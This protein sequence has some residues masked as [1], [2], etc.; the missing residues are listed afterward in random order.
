MEM[1][2]AA[3]STLEESSPKSNSAPSQ[4]QACVH[5]ELQPEGEP[6]A[7]EWQHPTCCCGAG[8]GGMEMGGGRWP[9]FAPIQR[10]CRRGG[11]VGRFQPLRERSRPSD[12]PLGG[13]LREWVIHPR[14]QSFAWGW[15]GD[16]LFFPVRA[17]PLITFTNRLA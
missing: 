8:G 13:V 17:V 4:G 9:G 5:H 1:S 10:N 14:S 6:R 11:E 16:L 3:S 12:H 15:L 7:A 2:G